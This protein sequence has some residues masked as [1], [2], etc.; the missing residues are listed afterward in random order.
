[1]DTPDSKE[2]LFPQSWLPKSTQSQAVRWAVQSLLR[3]L[4][5][6]PPKPKRSPW[7]R[8]AAAA[9]RSSPGF[10]ARE[11]SPRYGCSRRI[12]KH[13]GGFQRT[14]ASFVG[15]STPDYRVRNSCLSVNEIQRHVG[16][17]S[18]EF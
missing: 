8:P 7:T 1:M 13:Q 10:R 17:K 6:F 18:C 9:T 15:S 2:P 16:G 14:S 5:E 3:H 12:A 11:R 4:V